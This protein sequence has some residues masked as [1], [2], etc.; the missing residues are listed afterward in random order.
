[1]CHC[2][3]EQRKHAISNAK[4]Q[5]EVTQGGVVVTDK[6]TAKKSHPELYASFANC[7]TGH[8]NGLEDNDSSRTRFLFPPLLFVIFYK[9]THNLELCFTMCVIRFFSAE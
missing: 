4:K 2:E 9:F 3:Q 7:E 8:D 1:M 5:W 6:Q